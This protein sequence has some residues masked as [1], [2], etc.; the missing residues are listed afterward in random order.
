MACIVSIELGFFLEHDFVL[1]QE[2]DSRQSSAV[3]FELQRLV[4]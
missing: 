1:C 3:V 2:G 4:F